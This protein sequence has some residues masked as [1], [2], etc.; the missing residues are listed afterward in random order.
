MDSLTAEHVGLTYATHSGQT[1]ALRGLN[2]QID[3]GSFVAVL[4]PSGCGKSSLLRMFAGLMP[5]TQGR[6][7]QGDAIIAGPR[8]R[9]GIAFQKPT[10]MPWKSVL[11]NVLVPALAQGT[12]RAAA[13]RRAHTLLETVGLHGFTA[14][15][16]H[17]LSGGMQ[18]RVGLARMLITDPAILLMDEPFSALDALTRE[19]MMVEL[20]RLWLAEA[21]TAL[22]VTHS[23]AEAAFLS[24]RVLVMSPRPG[25]ITA[26]ITCDLPRPRTLAM[27]ETPAFASLTGRLRRALD[28]A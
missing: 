4:G 12:P 28:A 17:E 24:D 25:R 9:I 27:L 26:E 15:Y 5:P 14:A 16:P 3:A 21:K 23:I 2:L 6:L 18:Q 1:E 8:R 10:L 11:E 7:Q 20:Q 22:F 13:E 19:S